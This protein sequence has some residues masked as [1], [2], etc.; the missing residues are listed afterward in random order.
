M[1]SY[2]QYKEKLDAL[3]CAIG[4]EM[5]RLEERIRIHEREMDHLKE[6]YG[7]NALTGYHHGQIIEMQRE[8]ELFGRWSK[9][10]P[11]AQSPTL[12]YDQP[13]RFRG[14]A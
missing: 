1:A 4:F 13:N 8:L 3:Q 10:K 9:S 14:S 6:R 5:E 11:L 7:Q 12:L 2:K